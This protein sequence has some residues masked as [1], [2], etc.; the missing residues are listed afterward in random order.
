MVA[1]ASRCVLLALAVV[2]FAAAT[3]SAAPLPLDTTALVG[4][5]AAGVDPAITPDGRYAA[6]W[7]AL[8]PLLPDGVGSGIVRR[9]MVTGET[10]LASRADGRDGAPMTV[11]VGAAALGI[12][13]RRTIVSISADG[14][15][16]AF[17]SVPDKVWVRDLVDG[18]TVLA[19]R[20]DGTGPV[21]PSTNGAYPSISADGTRVEFTS[22]TPNLAPGDTDTLRDLFVRDLTANTTVLASTGLVKATGGVFEG[23]LSADGKHV[24]FSTSTPGLVTT[25]ND[26]VSDVFVRDLVNSTTKRVS[27]VDGTAT[28]AG[29]IS[30]GG[31]ISGDG[32]R[33]AFTSLGGDLNPAS[34][35]PPGTWE[36]WVHDDAD[37]S[38]TLASRADGRDGQ[39]ADGNA[40]APLISADG[41]VVTFESAA[42]NL[43]AAV[44]SG[45]VESYRRYLVAGTTQLVSRGD[46]AVGPAASLP[47]VGRSGVWGMTGD[48]A[49]VTF[50]VDDDL[51]GVGAGSTSAYMRT[52]GTT[53]S[54]PALLLKPPP[55]PPPPPPDTTP[56]VLSAVSLSHARFRVGRARTAVAATTRKPLPRG[57]VLRFTSSEA[58]R[59]SIRIER[60]RAGRK[61]RLH[62]KLVCRAIRRPVRRG[63]CT[64]YARV[65]TL[66]R[67]L[68]QAGRGSVALSGR[69]RSRRM[70]L[71]SYRLTIT[72]RD[73]AGN[74]SKATRRTMKILAG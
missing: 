43:F 33:V 47:R 29:S 73:A 35:V 11:D 36:T 45:A 22:S 27:V 15:R 8:T 2:A 62:G 61:V 70:A 31:S 9:D 1:R 68:K 42:T 51:L 17:V 10:V 24:V 25:D 67:T 53:C 3:A 55:P 30:V 58:G 57:T 49:C 71:G 66:T 59:L 48:G 69:I 40:Y 52:F 56:P 12:G 38:T 39:A 23:V 32:S 28:G 46:G 16:I 34:P 4:D 37:G 64:A 13:L 74:V 19:S 72:A 26:T 63:R 18:T 21:D 6:F 20:P 65:A 60:A 14:R 44:P 54:A 7:T 5:T 41:H 50:T